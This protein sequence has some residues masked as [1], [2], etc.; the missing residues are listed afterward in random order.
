MLVSCVLLFP[1]FDPSSKLDIFLSE[2]ILC[3]RIDLISFFYSSNVQPSYW[4]SS[5]R[6]AMVNEKEEEEDAEKAMKGEF[7]EEEPAGVVSGVKIKHLT[8]VRS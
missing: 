5:P 6:M 4:C 1:P 8:K 2:K 7:I 3:T